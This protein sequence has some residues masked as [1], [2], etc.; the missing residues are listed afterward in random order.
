MIKTSLVSLVDVKDHDNNLKDSIHESIKLIGYDFDRK[1]DSV[2][3]KPNMCYYW[4]ASTGYTTD[5]NVVGAIIDIIR[6][7]YD[8]ILIKIIESDASAMRVKHAFKA[9]DYEKLCKDKNVEFVNLSEVEYESVEFSIN[10]HNFSLRVPSLIL[11][12]DLLINVPK[13]K[14]IDIT[15]IT[16][17]MKNLF[18]CLS[19]KRKIKYHNTI[20][21]VIVALNKLITP[22][23]VI[24]DSLVAL[25]KHPVK[26]D[27][28]M[29]GVNPFSIDWMS[30]KILNRNPNNIAFLDL[31][32]KEGLGN[33]REIKSIG[34]DWKLYYKIL[35]NE[36]GNFI[37]P[38]YKFLLTLLKMYATII[39]DV[40][41]PVLE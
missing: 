10:N 21:E 7:N 31:A 32:Y 23:L 30:A 11:N 14:I 15:G 22:Q 36:K 1:I 34:K 13:L 25:T 33:P 24:V 8:D 28:I 29:A 41:P 19:I 4:K 35:S 37:N 16:C 9:L 20:N 39:G 38:S 26:L 2:L 40:I 3:I 6:D 17:A 5:P 12:G 27:L 18:G